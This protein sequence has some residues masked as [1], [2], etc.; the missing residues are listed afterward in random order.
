V[1]GIDADVRI[2]DLATNDVADLTIGGKAAGLAPLARAGLPVPPAVVIP[3]EARDEDIPALAAAVASRFA[4]ATLAVRSSGVAE[5][6]QHASFAGQYETVLNTPAA[7]DAVAAAVNRVRAS[8]TGAGVASYAGT[9]ATTMAV[10]V[11]PMIDATAA[12]IAFTRDPIT[13]DRGVI[14][15]AVRGLGHRLAAGEQIGERWRVADTTERLSDLGVLSE[16]QARAVAELAGQCEE[17][18]GRPQDVEWAITGDTVVL[19]QSRP[20]TTLDEVEPIPM[21]EQAPPGP[22]EWDSTHNR[23]PMT[24]LTTSLFSDG[25]ERASRRLAETYGAPIKQLSMRTINGY[26]Y[27]QVVPP[28]GK[29]GMPFPPKPVMRALFHVAPLLRQRKRA[30][31]RAV[32][33]RTD[34]RLL[35]QWNT[36]VRPTT[37]A[38]LDRWLDLDRTALSDEQL[39][40]LIVAMAELQ[41]ETFGWNMATDPAYLF[42]LSDL[43]EFVETELGLGMESTIRLLAGASPSQYLKSL[44]S[45]SERLGSQARETILDGD[46]DA[47]DGLETTDPEFSVAYRAHRRIH[48]LRI[49]GFDLADKVLLEEPDLELNRLATLPPHDDPT[50][51]AAH[52]AAELRSLI[53]PERAARFDELVAEARRTYPIREEG[54]SVHARTMGAVRLTALEAGRR[55]VEAGHLDRVEHVV[56]LALDEVDAWLRSPSD[57][58][59]LVRIRRGQQAW[60]RGRSPEPYLGGESPMPDVEIFP[61]DVQRIMRAVSLII[62]HDQRPADL[63]DGLDGVA[64]SPGVHTGPARI[65]TGASE[66]GKVQPGDVLIAPITASPWEVLFPHVGA[67]VTEGGGLLSHP[68]IVAREYRLPAVVGC[69]GAMSRF[70]DGQLVVVDGAAGTVT[71]VES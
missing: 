28:A 14:V 13:G 68:A 48:G 19:L 61:P 21:T 43:Q 67:L 69:E 59:G 55:M 1:K 54:E 17:V 23:L 71:A 27:I 42:P 12:G 44:T 11:M 33:Q 35:E 56:F 30:A 52:L 3:A 4:G 60:A 62:S 41:R 49:L 51:D 15:E 29:P 37:E 70:H 16:G 9:H 36:E 47:L 24:P 26:L 34:R 50:P 20:I 7:A 46:S 25:F 6:L 64:A 57:V 40:R 53:D 22:W 39:A 38:T 32:E 65:V 58:S 8:A 63:A 2:V 45:L 31:R 18:A 5:D 10:L 66:F